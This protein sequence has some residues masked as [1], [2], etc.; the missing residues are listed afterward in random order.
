MPRPLSRDLDD[1]VV[2]WQ[3]VPWPVPWERVF[4]RTGPLALEIG[5][6][7][8]AFLAEQSLLHPG[9]DHV[10][11]ELSWTAA[12]YLFRRLR[13]SAARNVRVVLGDAEFLVVNGFGPHS[14]A[15][16]FVNHPCPWPKARHH[17]RRLLGRA[18]LRVLAERMQTDARLTVV[19]DHAEYAEW[20][21]GELESQELLVSCHP[22][23][24]APPIAGR[25][26]TKYQL[27]AM[28]Q[29]IPIHYFEWRKVASPA[30]HTAQATGDPDAHMSTVTLSGSAPAAGLFDGFRPQLY[31]EQRDGVEI[32][33]RLDS[34]YRRPGADIW[35]VETLVLE[36]RL[37]Q[38]FGI[39]VI[40]RENGWLVKPSDMG[41]PYPTHGV[42]RAV[43]CVV[44][45]LQSRHPGLDVRNESLGPAMRETGEPWVPE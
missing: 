7:N 29:G 40:G 44:R 9:R 17:A 19:T 22:T 16:V 15:E 41:L 1:Y 33:V 23:V 45:W 36:D 24:E 30:V 39:D 43:W 26:P 20:L 18:F 11:I 8:G 35:L 25:A 13:R 5:F 10:G 38:C 14:L 6:G 34:V 21:G 31:R 42:K 12:T 3:R 32:V 37:K 27:R 2:D 4:G 28:A